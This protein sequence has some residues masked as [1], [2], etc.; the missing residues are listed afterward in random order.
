[1]TEAHD[2][3]TR[4]QRRAEYDAY[5]GSIDE[6]RLIEQMVAAAMNEVRKAEDAV[7]VAA[8]LPP[9]PPTGQLPIE[10]PS[11]PRIRSVSS[12]PPAMPPTGSFAAEPTTA[13][14]A[15][16]AEMKTGSVR[17]SVNDA[18][19]EARK[20]MLARRLTG[21]PARPN[22]PV[23]EPSVPPLATTTPA[24]AVDALKRRYE[25]TVVAARV[26]QSKKYMASGLEAKAR[27][28]MLAA[29]NALRVALSFDAD[30]AELKAAHDEAQR[31]SDSLLAEQYAKQGDYE[32]KAEKWAEAARSWRRVVRA[33]EG[34]LK[35][36]ERAAFC[37][38]KA[39]GDLHE[40][41]ALAQRAVQLAPK[42]LQA[43]LTLANVYLAAGLSKNAKREL[44]TAAGIAPDDPTVTALLKRLAKSG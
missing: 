3:L 12:V 13:T 23:S 38:L 17:I 34:D 24:D 15:L 32:E 26:S 8:P 4:D 41:S 18:M 21:R 2:T 43:R 6:S 11:Q 40:A 33:R 7:R 35:A 29:A 30:N 9:P 14:R 5:L 28:D 16:P 22:T 10:A 44:E 27:G 39:S 37:L 25:E 36:H 31:A 1:M 19:A 42:D 20:D